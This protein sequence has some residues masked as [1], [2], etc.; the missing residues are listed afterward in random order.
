MG[1]S[2][3]GWERSVDRVCLSAEDR[4]VN[5]VGKA[6]RYSWG[7]RSGWDGVHSL[8]F[9]VITSTPYFPSLLMGTS[10]GTASKAFVM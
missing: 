3:G 4:G 6:E 2:G 5:G 10:R 7:S 8:R 9:E 1:A